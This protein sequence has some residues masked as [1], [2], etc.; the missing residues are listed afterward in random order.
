MENKNIAGKVVLTILLMLNFE[1]CNALPNGNKTAISVGV[2]YNWSESG[3]PHAEDSHETYSNMGLSSKLITSPTYANLM[4]SHSN[5]TKHMESGIIY[6]VGHSGY[7]NVSFL[8]NLIV[9]WFDESFG[10]TVGIRSFNNSKTAFTTFAGCLTASQGD[11]NITYK[12]FENGTR[13]TM[14]WTTDLNIASYE[15]WNERF[16]NKIE[17]KSTSVLAA[18]QHASSYIYLSNTVKN[19]KIYGNMYDNPWE[20][21]NSQ[22]IAGMSN[23]NT[24]YKNENIEKTK[25]NQYLL[26]ENKDINLNNYKLEINGIHET[27]YDYVLYVDDIRTNLG[28]TIIENNKTNEFELK[29]NMK[30][31]TYEEIKEK[32]EKKKI[33]KITINDSRNT[34]INKILNE[35]NIKNYEINSEIKYY[36]I[37]NDKL[38]YVIE[39][40]NM[41]ND[42]YDLISYMEEI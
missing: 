40:K 15:N 20:S 18:A 16:N 24:I 7:T 25:S 10:T 41:Y 11:N 36:D 27:Y 3:V 42:S 38:Y 32:I 37:D 30:N 13:T 14:G 26:S 4:A 9:A 6:L 39:V 33:T 12:T 22:L 34:I 8:D 31:Y 29:N 1:V 5:G 2:R 23:K 35:K 19:Y 21:L 17:D 28:Y